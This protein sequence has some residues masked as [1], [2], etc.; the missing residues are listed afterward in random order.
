M[1]A[2]QIRKA[3]VAAVGFA[4]TVL[5]SILATGPDLIPNDTLPFVHLF[6]AL[7]GSYG[8][9]A[10]RNG[11]SPDPTTST[12]GPFYGGQSAFLTNNDRGAADLAGIGYFFIAVAVALAMLALLSTFPFGPALAALALGV[13]LVAVDRGSGRFS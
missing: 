1:T 4:L 3:L 2:A 8:V 10:V 13:V 6:I 9:Y 5:T 12:P 7:A 11:A